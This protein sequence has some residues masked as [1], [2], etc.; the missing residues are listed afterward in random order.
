LFDA[1]CN[2]FQ[3]TI[4]AAVPKSTLTQNGAQILVNIKA[5]QMTAHIIAGQFT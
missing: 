3:A 2:D 5:V 1:I 4:Q